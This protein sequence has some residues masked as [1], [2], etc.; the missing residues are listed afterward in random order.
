MI[1]PVNPPLDVPGDV[2]TDG[3]LD[4]CEKKD[5]LAGAKA[6]PNTGLVAGSS[7]VKG[8]PVPPT[9]TSDRVASVQ[10]VPL[11]P[12][13]APARLYCSSVG[14]PPGQVVGGIP[15]LAALLTLKPYRTP[16]TPPVPVLAVRFILTQG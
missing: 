12:A 11:M 6:S 15:P 14:E 5:A 2:A 13:Q 4:G 8:A 16:T 10:L 3:G 1:A 9:I 7:I